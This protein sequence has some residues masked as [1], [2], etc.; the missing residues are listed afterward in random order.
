MAKFKNALD[1]RLAQGRDRRRRDGGQRRWHQ[2]H[3]GVRRQR[4]LLNGAQ[5]YAKFRKLIEKA[6][7][8]VK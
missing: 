8:E 2:R 7:A 5:P 3:A 6:L 1:N 4:L